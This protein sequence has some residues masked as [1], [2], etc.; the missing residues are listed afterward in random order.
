MLWDMDETPVERKARFV[1]ALRRARE[2]RGL[3]PPQLADRLRVSRGT[4][5]RWEDP[6][7]KDAP[8]ILMLGV[9]CEKLGV[10]PRLWA[11]L[12]PEPPSEVDDYLVEEATLDGIARGLGRPRRRARPED[13]EASA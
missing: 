11:V 9:L 1:Y 8:S 6:L 7:R 4:V 5:N 13:T 10:E 12:P 2:K 3:T